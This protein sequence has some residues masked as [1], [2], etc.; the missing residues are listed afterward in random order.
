M[1]GASVSPRGICRTR[2][3]V[4][5]PKCAISHSNCYSYP[6]C[7]VRCRVCPSE[8]FFRA[9]ARSGPPAQNLER[10]SVYFQLTASGFPFQTALSSCRGSCAPHVCSPVLGSASFPQ[11][12]L[13]RAVCTFAINSPN[14]RLC[15]FVRQ[16]GRGGGSPD[17]M[18]EFS[19]VFKSIPF[20]NSCCSHDLR[21]CIIGIGVLN[22]QTPRSCFVSFLIV[23]SF[24]VLACHCLSIYW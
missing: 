13:L 4:C 23:P 18:N 15:T 9:T 20:Q 16:R 21:C 1:Q 12:L 24:I 3:L 2:Q 14:G 10:N 8:S 17:K 19:G 6:L 22:L 7:K 5:A 11:R